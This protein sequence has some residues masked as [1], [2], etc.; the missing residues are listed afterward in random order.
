MEN[1]EYE[2]KHAINHMMET[3]YPRKEFWNMDS[4][5]PNLISGIRAGDDAV[6]VGNT[7]INMEGPYPLILGSKTALI[8][9]TCDIVA[10]GAP[11]KYAM[12]AIQ[13]KD[14]QEIKMAI[15]GL[16]KQSLGL[17]IPIVGGNTQTL[18]ELKSC[19]S[20]VVFGELPDDR[21]IIKDGGAK[22]NDIIAM[23]GHPVEGDI[24]ARIQK[25]KNKFNTFLELLNQG[26]EVNACKD[27]SRGGWL[28]NLL[29]MLVKAKKGIEINSIPYPRATRY[30]GT[31]LVSMSEDSL[32]EAVNICMDNRCPIIPFGKITTDN[33][34]SIGNKTY[35]YNE[36]MRELLKEFPYKY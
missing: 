27:A 14:E 34:L 36:Q 1:I 15:N 4:K 23:V 31:Y 26:V 11:P 5:L 18:E 24:G 32:K 19:M 17:N 10:M 20:V 7:V 33:C 25:A 16:K 22:P 21:K 2:I 8:H 3:N 35:L 9:T 6:V 29:E 30:L 13:A 12:N 28:C